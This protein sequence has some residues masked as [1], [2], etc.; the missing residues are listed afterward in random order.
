[1]VQQPVEIVNT[2]VEKPNREPTL[3][4]LHIPKTAGLS[5]QA[6]LERQYAGRTVRD[7]W[8]QEPQ[9][10]R[11][12]LALSS[13]DRAEIA[14]LMGHLPFGWHELFPHGARYV[15]LLRDPVALFVSAMRYKDWLSTD[16]PKWGTEDVE[17]IRSPEE[18]LEF[19]KER[20]LLNVQ[21]AYLGGVI[22]GDDY[23]PP[24]RVTREH[25][26]AARHHIEKHFV[27]AGLT[28]R[29]DESVLLMKRKLGWTR[30]LVQPRVNV[31]DPR[32]P[33]PVISPRLEADIRASCALDM[34]LLEFVRERF[35]AEL[36]RQDASF[37]R[38]LE[39]TRKRNRWLHRCQDLYRALFPHGVR[40]RLRRGKR[41]VGRVSGVACRG[42]L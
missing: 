11:D 20:S 10:V 26:A 7:V 42:S 32:L 4:F 37:R 17:G 5:L 8:V 29:F 13:A 6:I 28:R 41:L 18:L 35:E 36:E 24:Y 25:L 9:T 14:C 2:A 31:T 12:F 23:Q 40:R 16:L 33:K 22:T 39:R 21:T 30:S 1:M 34:E 27:V 19:C 3:I 15:T 38:E